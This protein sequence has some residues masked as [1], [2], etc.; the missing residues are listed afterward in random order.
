MRFEV[1]WKSFSCVQLFA[2]P[3]TVACQAPLSM[4]FSRQ[5]YWGGL[6]FPIPEDIPNPGIKPGSPILQA[7]S[8]LSEPPGKPTWGLRGVKIYF[9][10]I[11]SSVLQFNRKESIFMPILYMVWYLRI[12]VLVFIFK[13]PQC[14]I[15][16]TVGL[17]ASFIFIFFNL[18]ETLFKYL[19]EKE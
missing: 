1:K 14:L 9:I 17:C 6:P 11:K 7:D 18:S 13:P 3:W 4:E 5:E 16:L 15:F 2:T 12:E 10:L 19:H 8:L